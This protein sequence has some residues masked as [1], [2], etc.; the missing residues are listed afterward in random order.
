MEDRRELVRGQQALGLGKEHLGFD[1]PARYAPRP[2]RLHIFGLCLVAGTC[3]WLSVAFSTASADKT[4]AGSPLFQVMPATA[5][6][7][8]LIRTI[9]PRTFWPAPATSG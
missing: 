9:R 7:L 6:E 1:R 2:I 3:A 4:P 8:A 5:R